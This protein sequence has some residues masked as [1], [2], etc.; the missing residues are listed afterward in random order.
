[1]FRLVL[2]NLNRALNFKPFWFPISDVTFNNTWKYGAAPVL[3]KMYHKRNITF[4][5]ISNTAATSTL[6]LSRTLSHMIGHII[7]MNHTRR[8]GGIMS[9]M[10]YHSTLSYNNNFSEL[11]LAL[12][13][14]WRWLKSSHKTCMF[15]IRDKIYQQ[16][17]KNENSTA[18]VGGKGH[19][20][21]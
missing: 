21:K 8:N 13:F 12:C 17:M 6:L 19:R 5:F 2:K 1:M 10:I 9:P 14:K 4:I 15:T 3:S 18:N 7:G 20:A 16:H 11:L